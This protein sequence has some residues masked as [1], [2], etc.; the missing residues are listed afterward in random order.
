MIEAMTHKMGSYE[1]E[2]KQKAQALSAANNKMTKLEQEHEQSVVQLASDVE[3]YKNMYED[4][5]KK[6][7]SSM[8]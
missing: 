2:L 8:R 3:H 4:V 6:I 1:E 5:K 7:N